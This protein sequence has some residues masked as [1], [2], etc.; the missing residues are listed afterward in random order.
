M[1]WWRRRL[2]SPD[3]TGG[4]SGSRRY[5]ALSMQQTSVEPGSA[6]ASGLGVD[7]PRLV[8][9]LP[10]RRLPGNLLGATAAAVGAL[11][12]VMFSLELWHMNFNV[13]LA[14][15]S[16]AMWIEI[17]VKSVISGGWI[18]H[19]H[20]LGAPLG[21][22][23]Y[24]FPNGTDN[25]NLLV[26]KVLGITSSNPG[27]VD[28]LFFLLT[29]VAEAVAAFLVFRW[30]R[31]S[32]ATS[33]VCAIL[34]A[35]AP[36]HL[37]RGEA[38]GLLSSYSTVPIAT[39]L[40][41]SVLDGNSVFVV[42]A[43]GAGSGVRGFV[44]RFLLWR[45]L[46]MIVLC[47]VIASTGVYYAI[48]AVLLTCVAGP[49]AA[50]ARRSWWPLAQAAALV[51]IIIG[52]LGINNAPSIIYAREHG[53]NTVAG[54]RIPAES[55]LY[56]L[57]LAEMVFPVPGH[58]IPALSHIRHK[59]DTTNPLP[60][61]DPQQSLGS[62]ATIGLAWLFC[63][64]LATI[65]GVGREATWLR[66]HRQL[67]FLAV[68]AF[69]IG[70]VG[71]ISALIGY[72]ITPEVR[73][74]DRISIYIAF[75]SLAA[76]GLLLDG[77][78]RRLGPRRNY[79]ALGIL[80]AIL[81]LGIFDQSSTAVV[82]PYRS[83]QAQYTNDSAFV[84]RID[85]MMPKGAAI[86]QLPYMSFPE[87]GPVNGMLDY[88]LARGYVYST[89]G[90]RWSY[91]AMKGRPQDW[92]AEVQGL[93][94]PT[95]ADGLV[96][97][98]FSGIWIDRYGYT[99]GAA[100]L[101]KSFQQ[102]LGVA[103]IHSSNGRLVF[104]DLR[105]FAARLRARVPGDELVGLRRAILYPPELVWQG[106]FYGDESGSRWASSDG[107]ASV[108]DTLGVS[109]RMMFSASVYSASPGRFHLTVI[110]PGAPIQTFT[111]TQ[112]P[113]PVVVYFNAPPGTHHIIF[114]SNVPNSHPDGDPRELAVRYDNLV[115]GNAAMSPFLPSPSS[116]AP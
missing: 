104:F 38:H 52:I 67:A 23:L 102:I 30:M 8:A 33:I 36:Y 75:F 15:G 98:G 105:P 58:R 107:I 12:A 103:P 5:P 47:V 61:E 60:S 96:A 78:R 74:Y 114:E 65:A 64:A 82:P 48:F 73:G 88:D 100:S 54:H 35:D 71:G 113:K 28:N 63:L 68:S 16:D 14:Y 13:P 69:L 50:L 42:R 4:P 111:I 53:R 11:I 41:L 90:L 91:G 46:W 81:V 79:W 37:F 84:A 17:L 45:N 109:T 34:F 62:V 70:T 44:S 21:T 27:V 29:F 19:I 55:E 66:R 40:I 80:A 57:K 56:A 2:A 92:A 10:R 77:L 3:P 108:E 1:Q 24:D 95:L 59:Y 94:L 6:L 31:I 20:G 39:Y 86:Y 106:G 97:A 7:E 101:M 112:K 43:A 87:N 93:P 76:V 72:L 110:A 49:A 83:N 51:V 85:R 26:M 25:L 99:D 89:T 115:V 22:Q 9:R 18:W 116:A 32:T